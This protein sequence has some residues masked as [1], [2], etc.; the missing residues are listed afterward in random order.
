M[1]L[2][3]ILVAVGLAMASAQH[4][5]MPAGMSHEE[6]LKQLQRNAALKKRGADAMGFD[7]DATV[8]HFRL[9]PTGGFI[10]V[11][12]RRPADTAMRGEIRVHLKQIAHDF[13]AGDF[14][15]PVATHAEVPPGVAVMEERRSAITY[16]YDETSL[17]ARVVIETNDSTARDA[18]H[19]FLRYQ[20]AEHKTGDPTAGKTPGGLQ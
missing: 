5:T 4:P 20:I 16:R 1:N 7:Q 14:G 15:K 18:I 17:G 10:A 3:T 12:V 9:T 13:G 8:H 11:D 6:H 19:A 2:L